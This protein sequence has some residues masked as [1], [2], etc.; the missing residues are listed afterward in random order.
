MRNKRKAMTGIKHQHL[1]LPFYSTG[2]I[3]EI[4][5]VSSTGLTRNNLTVEGFKAKEDC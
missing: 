3:C 2:F 5:K 1:I 4:L